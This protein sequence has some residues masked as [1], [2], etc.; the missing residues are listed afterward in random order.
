[1]KQKY[2]PEVRKESRVRYYL[3][4]LI[5]TQIEQMTLMGFSKFN[6]YNLFGWYIYFVAFGCFQKK[7]HIKKLT[8]SII[9]S[10][11][12]KIY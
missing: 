1:M 12:Y 4:L 8:N 11:A 6:I 3:R 10:V 9:P 2:Q 7:F 5:Q